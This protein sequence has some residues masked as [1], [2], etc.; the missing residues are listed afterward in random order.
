[1]LAVQLRVGDL[2]HILQLLSRPQRSGYEAVG[3]KG[4]IGSTSRRAIS[5]S[6]GLRQGQGEMNLI[7]IDPPHSLL[8]LAV[9]CAP[10]APQL[11]R[12]QYQQ[13]A[14]DMQRATNMRS[15]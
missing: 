6:T 5:G 7:V 2:I 11:I 4:K 10:T 12:P 15:P 13:R 1:M 8:V 9:I 14:S 3:A